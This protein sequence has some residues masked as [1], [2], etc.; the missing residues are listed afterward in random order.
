M[1]LSEEFSRNLG[2]SVDKSL[3]TVFTKDMARTQSPKTEEVAVSHFF[4]YCPCGSHEVVQASDAG[5]SATTITVAACQPCRDSQGA[6]SYEMRKS[7]GIE[8]YVHQDVA[9]QHQDGLVVFA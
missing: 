7:Y 1:Q 2:N 6:I 3:E 5:F 8:A 4:V 9:L